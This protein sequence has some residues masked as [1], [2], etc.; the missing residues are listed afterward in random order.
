MIYYSTCVV[1]PDHLVDMGIQK[2]NTP[3]AQFTNLKIAK[4]MEDKAKTSVIA[5]VTQLSF[6]KSRITTME[7]NIQFKF[8][9]NMVNG[10]GI[11]SAY[12]IIHYNFFPVP[13]G[14]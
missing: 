11:F 12:L 9:T 7:C 1:V 8:L 5:R 13:H 3:Q 14:H 10:S 2:Y 6:F 4:N